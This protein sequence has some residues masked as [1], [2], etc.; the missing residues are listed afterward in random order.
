MTMQD[1]ELVVGITPFDEPNAALAVALARAG[2]VG[3]LNLGRD[4][5]Q[6]RAALADVCRWWGGSFGIRV[7]PE[8]PLRPTDLPD[9]VDMVVQGPGSPWA[10]TSGRRVFAE[11]VSVAQ[12][13]AAVQAGAYGL[14][15]KGAEAGGRVGTTTTFVLLQQLLADPQIT[16]PV[17]A[18]GGIGLHTAAAAVAGGAAGVVLDAQLALVAEADLP[19]EVAAAIRLMDGSET[20]VVGGHRL[21]TRPDLP[22]V[23]PDSVGARL[24]ARDLGALP[25]GQDGALA[26]FLAQRYVTAGGVVAAI[27]AAVTDQLSAARSQAAHGVRPLVVQ[28]PMTRVSDRA[29]FAAEVAAAGGLPF[30]ALALSNGEQT[31]ALLEQSA[32]QLD[33]RPWGVG[34]LGFVPP[35]I[36]DAQ[37]AAVLQVRPPYAL[38]AGGRPAQARPLEAAGIATF[39]HVP[40]PGLL[41][42]FLTEGA[43]RF[44]FEGRE[45]GGHIGPQAS[46]PLWEIQLE[47]LLRYDDAHGCASQLQV[48][49]AGG[50]HDERSAAMVA[51]LAAPLVERGARIGMLMGTAY[52]F[53]EEAIAAGAIVPGFQQAALGCERTVLLETAP[54]HSTRCAD[55]PYLRTFAQTRARMMADGVPR[56]QMWA[57]LEQLNLGRLR[58]AS[59]GLRRDGASLVAVDEQVQQRD[60]MIM[61]GDVAMLR[62][63]TTTIETLHAQVTEGAADFIAARVAEL[64]IEPAHEPVPLP[65]SRPLD[66]AIVGMAGVFP[67]A[68]DLSAYWANVV[69][70][71]DSVT[72]V[73][74]GRCDPAVY[75]EAA[76]WG[77]GFLPDIPFDA[78]TYGIPPAALTSIEPVQLLA[79]EVAARALRDAGYAQRVFDKEHTSVIFGAEGG[80]DLASAYGFR[81]LYPA[82]HG[83][84]PPELDEQLPKV[85]EDSFPGVLANVIAGRIANRLDLGGA[86]YTVDAACA[87]ALAAIDLA[88]KELRAGTSSMVLAGGADVNNGIHQY[89]MFAA[90]QALSQTGRCRPFDASADGIALGE[91]VACV[92]LKRLADA[93]RDGDRIYA[94]IKGIGSASDGRSLGLT[95]PRPEG[96]RRALDRA[97]RMAGISPAEVG[98]V[99]AHGTGTVVGDRTE[100]AVLTELFTAA[101]TPTGSCSLGSVKSQIGHTKCTAGLAGLIKAA[102]AVHTGIRPP[103][104]QLHDPNPYW[105]RG[106]SP[107]SFDV[108]VRPWASTARRVAGVSAFGFG[109]TNFHAVLSSYDGAPEPR[110]GLDAWPAELF[111]FAGADRAAAVAEMDRLAELLAANDAAGRPWRLRDLAR[112]MVSSCRGRVWA[113]VVADDLDDLAPKLGR[114]REAAA[115]DGVF[116]A[117]EQD[118]TAGQ[119]AFLFPGQG[120][121]RP[122]M[123]ADLFVAFPRLRRFLELGG[124]WADAMF[125]PAAFSKEEAARQRAALT[126]TR[127]AQPALGIAGL[128]MHELLTLLGVHPDH[129]GGHSYGELVA[130]AAAG[131]VEPA[132][133]LALSQARGQAILAAAGPDPGTMAAISATV[134]QVHAVLGNGP[135][136]VA[137]HNAPGQ[138][139]ISGPTPAVQAALNRLAEVGVTGTRI[140][141]A[142]AFH[143]P[144]VAG[145]SPIFAAELDRRTVESPRLPV[146]SNTTAAP[147]PTEPA[148]VRATLATHIAEPVR[149]VEQIEAMYAAGARVF[150]EAGPGRVLTQLIGT[151][152]RDRPYVAVATDVP[153]EPGLRR[154]LRVLGEL[155]VKGVPVD[156]TALFHGRNARVVSMPALPRRPGWLVNGYLVKTADGQY[157]P[158]GLRPARQVAKTNDAVA[159]G[160]RPATEGQS[161]AVVLEFLRNTRELIAA[162]REIM[163]GYLGSPVQ[164]PAGLPNADLPAAFADT[165]AADQAPEHS[166]AKAVEPDDLTPE[167]VLATV[168][169]LVSERTGYPVDMLEAD[170]DLE[171]DLSIDSIKR[172]ELIGLLTDRLGLATRGAASDDSVTEQL[173]RRRTIRSIVDWITDRPGAPA[174]APLPKKAHRY[175]VDV[176]G[177]PPLA[178]SPEASLAGRRI[179]I[180]G[181][182]VGIALELSMLLERRGADVR[183]VSPDQPIEVT[184]TD[185][186]IH[187]AALDRGRPPLLPDGF[188]AIRDAILGGIGQLIVVTG[189]GGRFGRGPNANGVAGVGLPGLARTIAREFPDRRVRAVDV[190]PKEQPVHIAGYLLGELLAV[191]APTVVGYA[192]GERVTLQLHPAPLNPGASGELKLGRDSVVLLTGGARGITARVAIGLARAGA[193]HVELVGRTPA[194][195]GGEDPVTAA[196]TDRMALRRVLAQ[197]G[198]RTP[199]QIEAAASQILAHREIRATLAQL[200]ELAGSVRYSAVDVRDPAAMSALLEDVYHRHGRLD[201]I[202]H[203]AGV[204][205]DRL[206]ADKSPEEFARVWATK[207]DGA[208]ALAGAVRDDLGFLV[209]FGSVSGV[210]GNRG[211]VDYA[212]ANDALDTLARIWA[213]RTRGR[214]VAVD[215]GPWTAPDD[216]TGMV[217]AEVEREYARRGIG[218]IEPG[219]GVA[220]LLAELAGGTEPQVMY[221]CGDPAAFEVGQDG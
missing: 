46:F 62:S 151:I 213:G 40:S 200:S 32:V 54:N 191:D 152:L 135:V 182:G 104:G 171:A 73:P 196:A 68:G 92:V 136:V 163:L 197:A 55:T 25:I 103:T 160:H 94:V 12:A 58:I 214:V 164:P 199:A 112:T 33:G 178:A 216:G 45:C 208:R 146:W 121:Q 220:C 88:C 173:T 20:A 154:L 60:G 84:L 64:D 2:A 205:A 23:D 209:L 162:Q 137:N 218:L 109:G 156:P 210:F 15:A 134:E 14:I 3:V 61:L 110:H 194:P 30:L 4:A 75:S 38:I 79:L 189:S 123:L 91:G 101:G 124:E 202:V 77:G 43:R 175:L 31:R 159:N 36:R 80:A 183:M 99:E 130:L 71:V 51:T 81:S 117:S 100:L 96:Q 17:W 19:D 131:A 174:P 63:E 1:H 37:L 47:R 176:A 204:L 139:V 155:A 86:N 158:G 114:A 145:A 219:D 74:P 221:L 44:V 13:R 147:Y 150:V 97:Y 166:P 170:L 122:G 22:A 149:F 125:P 142:C 78:L 186:L 129:V 203:G 39:L 69:A 172:T 116:I 169:S 85:T 184:G 119:V 201:G 82:Y 108:A 26:A 24:G 187:L 83:T 111:L 52:L 56:D 10:I 105:D 5:E 161:D 7:P 148:A 42:R 192:A 27:R 8:C 50:I 95:A 207:V 6:A 120:S 89:L 140:P 181:D 67:G 49:F 65:E 59:K 141:V 211:Q 132:D 53:T 11:V 153:G 168:R 188:V 144:V 70:G 180:V 133:L 90:V 18:A 179:A 185:A 35:E 76:K 72:E 28:G 193:G 16:V 93:E 57:E 118:A 21:Y 29:E 9:Q 212:A 48:L 165:V 138:V 195:T 66:V 34:I 215:W 87:S 198:G 157:L 177:L 102:R 143:S 106:S 167:S 206:L 128:A 107:F 190:D 127:V 41:D 113:A 115:A 217:S 98:L 126:D